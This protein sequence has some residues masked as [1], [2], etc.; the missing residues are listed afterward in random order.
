MSFVDHSQAG[1][2]SEFRERGS[3]MAEFPEFS[4]AEFARTQLIGMLPMTTAAF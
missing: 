3:A 1:M 4:R 2:S